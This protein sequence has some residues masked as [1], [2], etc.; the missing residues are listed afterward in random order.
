M[1]PAWSERKLEQKRA[2][3]GAFM[4]DDAEFKSRNTK[5]TTLERGTSKRVTTL[6]MEEL[7]Q[8]RESHVFIK[9]DFTRPADKVQPGVPEM[10]HP[11]ANS[12]RLG[13][14]IAEK[15]K[16]DGVEAVILTST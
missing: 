6:V 3:Y 11:L 8:P 7:K 14:E 5:L 10:L 2:T 4:A 9:G 1:Q 12:R 16:A 13:R 15:L